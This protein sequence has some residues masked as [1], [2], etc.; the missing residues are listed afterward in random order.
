MA[1]PHVQ[2]QPLVGAPHVKR[3]VGRYSLAL[4]Q[5]VRE[6]MEQGYSDYQISG[7]TGL[8]YPLLNK[9]RKSFGLV[10]K[11][12]EHKAKAKAIK[13]APPPPEFVLESSQNTI[14]LAPLVPM[15]GTEQKVLADIKANTPSPATQATLD[16]LSAFEEKLRTDIAASTDTADSLDKIVV[17]GLLEEVR[18]FMKE[19]PPLKDY[20]DLVRV[21][22]VIK[23]K[24]GA[25]RTAAPESRGVDM[26]VLRARPHKT[27][28]QENHDI[29]HATDGEAGD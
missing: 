13:G 20:A 17:L 23:D 15:A 12:A 21:L 5:H 24:S 19:R 10:K 1:V 6:L 9:W 16:A 27:E 22:N 14:P 3:K 25:T 11:S 2:L 28:T 7:H 29:H 26:S 18:M 8:Q 4:K